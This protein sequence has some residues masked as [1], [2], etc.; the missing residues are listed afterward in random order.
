VAA[1]LEPEILVV[2]EV[3]AVG[4]ASF[5]KKCLGKM[6][7]VADREGR[8]ILFVSHQMPMVAS[9]CNRCLLMHNGLLN[10][11]GRPSS[12]IL[13]YQDAAHC[14]S[15]AVDYTRATNRPGDEL[16]QLLRAWVADQDGH[17]SAE[18]AI[19]NDF[20]I[21]MIYRL[22]CESPSEPYPNLHF[23]DSKGD[24]AFVTA[25]GVTPGRSIGPGCYHAICKVPGNLLNDGVY[26]VGLALTFGHNG[27]HVSFFDRSS[28]NFAV[29]DDMEEVPTRNSGY[30]GP[31]PGIVRPLLQWDVKAD[32]IFSELFAP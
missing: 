16:A 20:T 27:I 19:Q 26:S 8:T 21:H 23:Y 11:D 7:D 3:L 5:Q 4:D 17:P 12:V 22:L 2:D 18:V 13:K 24:C 31:M 1:H 32:G 28:L 29:V 14:G 15:A 6:E 9:L 10:S 25:A 30:V